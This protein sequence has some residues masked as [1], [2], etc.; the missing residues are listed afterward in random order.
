VSIFDVNDHHY[1]KSGKG[2]SQ[3]GERE[4][5]WEIIISMKLMKRIW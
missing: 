3:K 1:G 2:G 4:R 5:E